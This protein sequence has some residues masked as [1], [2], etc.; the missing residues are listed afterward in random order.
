MGND[1]SAGDCYE[2]CKANYEDDYM[3]GFER[4]N[5]ISRLPNDSSSI[6]SLPDSV[7]TVYSIE[8]NKDFYKLNKLCF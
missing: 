3:W 1:V 7:I 2:L 6:K 8:R 5:C 4:P